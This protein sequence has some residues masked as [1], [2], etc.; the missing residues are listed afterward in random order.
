[1][2]RDPLPDVLVPEPW[3]ANLE[4]A[5]DSTARGTRLATS[6]HQGPLVVQRPL[7]PEGS[8]VC[9][10]IVV[11]PPGGIA[12][13]DELTIE[14]STSRG[15]HAVLTTPGAGKLYK[16]GGRRASQRVNL[17]A[18]EG[19]VLEWLPQETIVFDAAL[20]SLE[21]HVGVRVGG[22]VLAWEVV[23]L[24]REAAGERYAS[25]VLDTTIAVRIDDRN[26]WVERGR[27]T[28]GSAWLE[29][30][31]GWRGCRTSGTFIAG[32]RKIDDGLVDECRNALSAWPANAAVTRLASECLVGRYLGPTASDARAAFMSL[33]AALRS[34]LAGR[35]AQPL[36]IWAT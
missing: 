34:A 26:V 9:H 23:T 30:P 1:M 6:R 11:H 10:A 20:A 31:I 24:G 12:G 25:G 22:L 14:V 36:R 15:A 32:G 5:F 7:Y 28:G 33:R 29:S 35:E 13:G 19:S 21:L 18:V 2:R 16:S 27:V 17:H 8:D 4:L 3:C